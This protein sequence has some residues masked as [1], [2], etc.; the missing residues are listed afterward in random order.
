MVKFISLH[1]TGFGKLQDFDLR[2][3]DGITE[4]AAPNGFGKT[5]VAAF[6]KAMLYGLPV[7]RKTDIA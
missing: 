4:V 2:F 3:S 5:T 1:V 7:L 6:I